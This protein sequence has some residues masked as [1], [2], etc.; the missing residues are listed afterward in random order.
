VPKTLYI[1]VERF[2]NKDAVSVYR[3]FRERGRLAPSGLKHSN[4][5]MSI[6]IA[7]LCVHPS[8]MHD[9]TKAIE[10]IHPRMIRPSRNRSP[11]LSL[12]G[13]STE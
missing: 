11:L 2:K 12:P 9:N 7:G 10:L 4:A 13:T 1:V 3:R 6:S 5:S 8:S